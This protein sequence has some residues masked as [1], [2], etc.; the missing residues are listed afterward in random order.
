[1]QISHRGGCS[2]TLSWPISLLKNICS[3]LELD[4]KL[5]PSTSIELENEKMINFYNSVLL[6]IYLITAVDGKDGVR[7]CP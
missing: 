2:F 7:M 3:V 6:L 1:M 4:K 5:S